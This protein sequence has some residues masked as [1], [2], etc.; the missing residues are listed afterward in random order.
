M[1]FSPN[2][3][4]RRQ[5]SR[6]RRFAALMLALVLALSAIAYFKT[7]RWANDAYME[8]HL[9]IASE[10]AK[11]HLATAIGG[12]LILME[13]LSDSETLRLHLLNPQDQS[14]RERAEIEI[15]AYQTLLKEGDIYWSS[16]KDRLLRFIGPNPTRW[17][18]PE[19]EGDA[20]YDELF[21]ANLPFK[22]G[23]APIFQPGNTLVYL[24]VPVFSFEVPGKTALGLVGSAIDTRLL[25]VRIT[26]AFELI[27][28]AFLYYIF[29]ENF[30][31]ICSNDEVALRGRL[32][33][34]EVMP[35]VRRD[36]LRLRRAADTS[37]NIIPASHKS[38][39]I[40]R[41]PGFGWFLAITCPLPAF[42]AISRSVNEV[43]FSMLA[44][45]LLTVVAFFIYLRRQ[46]SPSSETSKSLAGLSV[47][48]LGPLLGEEFSIGEDGSLEKA[49]KEA[50]F[51]SASEKASKSDSESDA[52]LESASL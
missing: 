3:D 18:D 2:A 33:V 16:T 35:E 13:K 29:D 25:A 1:S 45:C 32:S 37:D 42:G 31:V 40:S 50:D 11:L 22:V 5:A 23:P 30:H 46:N 12:E 9:S 48:F 19:I 51:S 8:S 14:L 17:I 34:A 47:P 21:R 38:H 7:A 52:S 26:S 44:I 15:G 6:N 41:V 24:S 20:W 10:I 39:L 36:L 49:A 43:F 27:D 28:P 4:E